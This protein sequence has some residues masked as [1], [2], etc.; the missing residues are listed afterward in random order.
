MFSALIKIQYSLIIAF[1]P[2]EKLE[3]VT[4]LLS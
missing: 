3:K 4:E 1:Y 2:Y